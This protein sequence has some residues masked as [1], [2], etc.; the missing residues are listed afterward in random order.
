MPIGACFV[1]CV[2][3]PSPRVHQFVADLLSC[4]VRVRRTLGG[5]GL[6]FCDRLLHTH[7]GL[8]E[9]GGPTPRQHYVWSLARIGDTVR[10][11]LGRNVRV[12]FAW[13]RATDDAIARSRIRSRIVA[14]T[15]KIWK[16]RKSEVQKVRG[17][18]STSQYSQAGG[19]GFESRHPLLIQAAQ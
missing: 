2:T 4:R 17:F 3:L 18:A 13:T 12:S 5:S 10:E 14:K 8:V 9:V 11:Q 7:Y 16:M 1:H 6:R 19:R 15:W